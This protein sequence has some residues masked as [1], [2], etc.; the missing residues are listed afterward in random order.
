MSKSISLIIMGLLFSSQSWAF[1]RILCDGSLQNWSVHNDLSNKKA[2]VLNGIDHSVLL[3]KKKSEILVVRDRGG[4]QIASVLPWNG[5]T[6]LPGKT[7]S[8]AKY[9]FDFKSDDYS[10][11][12]VD[13][14]EPHSKI[15]RSLSCR[16]TF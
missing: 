9:K 8:K 11:F 10:W 2:S 16:M 12:T 7:A 3:E 15:K 6:F 13:I 1:D 4:R 5:V 14:S